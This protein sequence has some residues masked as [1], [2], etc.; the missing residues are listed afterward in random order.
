MKNKIIP[1]IT[2][3][4][5]VTS[6]SEVID[7]DIEEGDKVI[8]LN[9]IINPDST[10]RVNLAQ[11]LSVL[12]P[13]NSFEFIEN[14]TVELYENGTLLEELSYDTLGYYTGQSLLNNENT[15]K[16]T[17]SSSPFE[18]VSAE[19]YIPN[20]VALT[21]MSS[22]FTLDSVTVQMWNPQTQEYFDTIIVEMSDDGIVEMT[23]NDPAD[24]KNFYFITFTT[25]LPVYSY[26]FDQPVQIG[27]KMTSVNYDINGL[28]WENYL[29]MQGF[30]GYVF[31][32]DLFDGETHTV[33]AILN[34]WSF[35]S[36]WYYGGNDSFPGSA[37]YV[38]L[39]SVSEDFFDFVLSYSKYQDT[40]YNPFAEP[41]NVFSNIENGF[42]L[43]TAYSTSTDSITFNM[44]NAE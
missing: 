23:F 16:I 25:M 2:L 34:R 19:A 24:E 38:N 21:G 18:S 44:D 20:P 10:V 32:D 3:L 8:V 14:A 17:A 9:G 4:I 1:I 35:N 31:S 43:F 29:Y 6:C 27:E 7:I 13:D 12:E 37:I 28:D 11:S 40:E 30:M 5:I 42:G 39:H 41:V 22:E 15:Y 26:D 36:S 33:L